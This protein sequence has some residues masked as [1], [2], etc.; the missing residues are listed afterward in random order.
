MYSLPSAVVHRF[1]SLDLRLS[2]SSHSQQRILLSSSCA[3]P[4]FVELGVGSG[5]VTA[6]L[7]SRIRSASAVA[8][9]ISPEAV[10]LA[11]E[12][13]ERFGVSS[14][15]RLLQADGTAFSPLDISLA[16]QGEKAEGAE[17]DAEGAVDLVV[18]N[19][20]YI[21]SWEL[22]SLARE[23]RCHEDPCA[24]AGGEP[25]GAGVALRAAAGGARGGYLRRGG[26]VLLETHVLHPGLLAALLHPLPPS[27][28]PQPAGRGGVQG[29][30]SAV[31]PLRFL[32]DHTAEGCPALSRHPRLRLFRSRVRVSCRRVLALALGRLLAQR[33]RVRKASVDRPSCHTAHWG[34]SGLAD[35]W[36]GAAGLRAW[37]LR[38]EGYHRDFAGRPRFVELRLEQPEVS[39]P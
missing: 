3:A 4:S 18:S 28:P 16:E 24:L 21:P 39:G 19:P 9:D 2:S 33:T 7:L 5:A 15:V 17:R 13:F 6:A 12:N 38:F 1:S 11:R 37:G 25:A 20:P 14:R 32:H 29:R 30:G 22:G 35:L 34:V 26:A 8:I 23:V 36:Q 10:A 31:P 27:T